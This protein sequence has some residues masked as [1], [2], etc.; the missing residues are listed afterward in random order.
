[1]FSNR[2]FLL[3]APMILLYLCGPGMA[4]KPDPA[5][6]DLADRLVTAANPAA[7]Q[8]L[9]SQNANL[10]NSDLAFAVLDHAPGG[11]TIG[12]RYRGASEGGFG[13][14]SGFG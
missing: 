8:E 4:Q 3:P 7:Q 5:V 6:K 14:S 1:M 2:Y 12:A 13:T 11:S 9:L 10:V